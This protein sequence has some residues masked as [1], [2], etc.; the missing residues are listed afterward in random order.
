MQP[1]LCDN[2]CAYTTSDYIVTHRLVT[3]C[4]SCDLKMV[5]R[6]RGAS[7]AWLLTM[8]LTH[9][10]G[11]HYTAICSIHMQDAAKQWG[12]APYA[13]VKLWIYLAYVQ[14]QAHWASALCPLLARHQQY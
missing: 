8:D 13:C 5:T 4:A 11:S 9:D 3:L 12:F 10:S 6:R 2:C 1:L 7:G 14:P